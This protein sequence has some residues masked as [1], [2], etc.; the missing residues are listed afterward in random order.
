M[1]K[2]AIVT[3]LIVVVVFGIV[4]YASAAT[5]DSKTVTV[6]VTSR[7]LLTMTVSTAT[8]DFGTVDPGVVQTP[9]AVTVTVASN[10]LYNLTKVVAGQDALM[11][12]GTSLATHPAKDLAKTAGTPAVDNYSLTMPWTTDPGAYTATVVYTAAQ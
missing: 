11:G 5:T 4:A 6:K 12:L 1:K 8:V 7:A 3:V 9:Q 2:L 10:A